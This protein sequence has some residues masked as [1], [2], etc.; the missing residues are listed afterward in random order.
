M[1]RRVNQPSHYLQLSW[2]LFRISGHWFGSGKS[3][4][5]RREFSLQM[6][7]ICSECAVRVVFLFSLSMSRK[8]R[9]YHDSASVDDMEKFIF[10]RQFYTLPAIKNSHVIFR[11]LS[12]NF[13]YSAAYDG[14]SRTKST[15]I[16]FWCR[17]GSLM[18]FT[19]IN[20]PLSRRLIDWLQPIPSL[21]DRFDVDLS[22]K[23]TCLG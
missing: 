11:E 4:P 18:K 9:R 14:H 20:R 10:S 23:P 16:S 19:S 21:I 15:I 1:E 12:S 5:T 3:R 22:G 8:F 2:A 17:I 13:R 7:K 6:G